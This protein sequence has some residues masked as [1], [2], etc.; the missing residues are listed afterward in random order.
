M[1][2]EIS[3]ATLASMCFTVR[4]EGIL[5]LFRPAGC[6]SQFLRERI[7]SALQDSIKLES[8]QPGPFANCP[9]VGSGQALFFDAQD[10][11]RLRGQMTSMAGV[12]R[13]PC[14][15]FHG[16]W[17]ARPGSYAPGYCQIPF[18]ARRRRFTLAEGVAEA[19][20]GFAPFAHIDID[21]KTAAAGF[22]G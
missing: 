6:G 16:F 10:C 5:H 8:V 7:I 4:N 21:S 13:I 2:R 15:G 3:G 9:E 11:F 14:W 1:Q 22:P 12:E 17:N 20:F 18:S 19:A